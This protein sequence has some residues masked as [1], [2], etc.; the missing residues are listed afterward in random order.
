MRKV[1]GVTATVGAVTSLVVALLNPGVHTTEVDLNDGGVWVTN[2]N[3]RLVAHL[4]YPARLL[5]TGL[6]AASAVFNVFQNG[7]QVL[8]SDGEASTLTGID[9]SNA[10]LTTPVEY[11]GMATTAGG[12]TVAITDGVSGKVWIQDAAAPA[13]FLPEETDPDVTDMPGALTA[14]GLDG[15][16]HV[17]SAASAR[18]TS[19]VPKG[20][21]KETADE[22]LSGGGLPL[23]QS[24]KLLL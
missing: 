6:R 4:N 12:S 15:S 22:D 24:S 13:S 17:V 7:E 14:V 18:L 23:M 2:A 5:D 11:A 19:V 20:Q 9:V 10:A 3:L 8:V 16:V 1:A 21:V